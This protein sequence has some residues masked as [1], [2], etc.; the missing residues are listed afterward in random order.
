MKFNEAINEL[1]DAASVSATLKFRKDI[2]AALEAA[3]QVERARI[4]ESLRDNGFAATSDWILDGGH[5]E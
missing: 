2:K 5:W 4:A 1:A 3:M